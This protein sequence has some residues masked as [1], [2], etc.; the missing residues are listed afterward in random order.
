M[1]QD[2]TERRMHPRFEVNC[3]VSFFSSDKL[4]IAETLDLSLGGMKIQSRHVLFIGE[5]YDFTVV[6]K[7]R[8]LNPKGKVAH[9]RTQPGLTYGVGVS[10]VKLSKPNKARLAKFLSTYRS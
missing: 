6:I 5:T 10:F 3:P 8:G 4:R 2:F 1:I 7:G 9:I